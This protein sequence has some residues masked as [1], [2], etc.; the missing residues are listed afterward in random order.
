[1]VRF[2]IFLSFVCGLSYQ[3]ISLC[4]GLVA[5]PDPLV[6]LYCPAG[7]GHCLPG[8]WYGMSKPVEIEVRLPRVELHVREPRLV[9][10]MSIPPFLADRPQTSGVSS[11]SVPS[12]HP[13]CNRANG[14]M[15]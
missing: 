8:L 6:F 3:K 7:S 15:L 9:V 12:F 1:M 13:V 11:L 14:L 2:R 10:F 4:L 5:P